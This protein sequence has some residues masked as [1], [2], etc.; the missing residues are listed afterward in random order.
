MLEVPLGILDE[1]VEFAEGALKSVS[2]TT[3]ILGLAEI[4]PG[5]IR[6]Q[7]S[8]YRLACMK[9][10]QTSTDMVFTE[11]SYSHLSFF[12]LSQISRTG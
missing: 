3:A 2:V 11:P 7:S 8:F 10:L 1:E 5:L 9:H 6:L 12:H 4:Q